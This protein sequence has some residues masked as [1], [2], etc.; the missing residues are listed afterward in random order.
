METGGMSGV[1]GDK[2]SKTI[3]GDGFFVAVLRTIS[4]HNRDPY[5]HC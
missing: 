2:T 4:N 5:F 3:S 1:V